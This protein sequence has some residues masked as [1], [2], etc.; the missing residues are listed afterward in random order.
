MKS[1][2]CGCRDDV[3]LVEAEMCGKRGL[4]KGLRFGRS[5]EA[6]AFLPRGRLRCCH[7]STSP[8]PYPARRVSGG[9]SDVGGAGSNGL[10]IWPVWECFGLSEAV[11][12]PTR[13]LFIEAL[14]LVRF[15]GSS[16]DSF[17]A[18]GV[19]GQVLFERFA[20]G[21]LLERLLLLIPF[22]VGS[23]IRNE[24]PKPPFLPTRQ[25]RFAPSVF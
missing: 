22:R 19:S 12:C 10:E 9:T 16:R 21:F 5:T 6:C 1:H 23:E 18:R 15:P 20:G 14:F 7:R 2:H 3:A 4:G 24:R 8:C 17:S 11:S 13:R 25:P